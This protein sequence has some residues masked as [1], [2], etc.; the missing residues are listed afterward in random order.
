MPSP[1]LKRPHHQNEIKYLLYLSL[2]CITTKLYMQGTN[3]TR[4]HFCHCCGACGII[5]LHTCTLS[6]AIGTG[7]CKEYQTFHGSFPLNLSHII[8][9]DGF[10]YSLLMELSHFAC[11]CR[12]TT[13]S[14][15]R[16]MVPAKSVLVAIIDTVKGIHICEVTTLQG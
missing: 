14:M 7:P 16:K 11:R 13:L 3:T 12:L 4:L 9:P 2:L 15:R 6:T 10:K 5:A 1:L 8:D